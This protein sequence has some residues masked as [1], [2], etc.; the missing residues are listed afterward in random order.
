MAVKPMGDLQLMQETIPLSIEMV[1]PLIS[2]QKSF[3]ALKPLR[4]PATA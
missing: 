4:R 2:Q 3:F 1:N